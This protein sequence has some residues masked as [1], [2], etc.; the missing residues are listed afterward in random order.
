[1][2]GI[3]NSYFWIHIHVFFTFL[4]LSVMFCFLTFLN[5]C[6]LNPQ[7]W[8]P[9]IKRAIASIWSSHQRSCWES[10]GCRNIVC[11][12]AWRMFPVFSLFSD[13]WE[14][15]LSPWMTSVILCHFIS[16][17]AAKELF[18]SNIYFPLQKRHVVSW[19]R[20]SELWFLHSS[21]PPFSPGHIFF[22][23]LREAI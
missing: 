5:S 20:L 2:T 23:F 17:P 3:E 9:W 15:F 22:S 18:L 12:I 1:M 21:K 10:I 7:I 13:F 11:K 6:W 19:L 8:N 16:V 4:E 14:T